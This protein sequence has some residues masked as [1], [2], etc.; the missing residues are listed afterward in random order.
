MRPRGMTRESFGGRLT[1][2]M[3]CRN[4]LNLARRSQYPRQIPPRF[5]KLLLVSS[6]IHIGT[7]LW[8]GTKCANFP[9]EYG[10]RRSGKTGYR[11]LSHACGHLDQAQQ[12]RMI[13]MRLYGASSSSVMHCRRL[14]RWSVICIHVCMYF[15]H[16]IKDV[17]GAPRSEVAERAPPCKGGEGGQLLPESSHAIYVLAVSRMAKSQNRTNAAFCCD[18]QSCRQG[19]FRSSMLLVFFSGR[20]MPKFGAHRCYNGVAIRCRKPRHGA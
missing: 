20:A 3:R 9:A 11:S 18:R 5:S 10:A 4:H 8:H 17:Q 12:F 7:A 15:C 1:S 19:I 14:K 13:R 2:N 6:L 16:C